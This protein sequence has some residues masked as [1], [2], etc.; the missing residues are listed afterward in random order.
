MIKFILITLL[1]SA[2]ILLP[3]QSS[4]GL[5]N[6]K[7]LKTNQSPVT[8]FRFPLTKE[9]VSDYLQVKE[10][11]LKKTMTK[12][13]FSDE[14]TPPSPDYSSFEASPDI[15]PREQLA[16]PIRSLPPVLHSSNSSD[17]GMVV[18]YSQSNSLTPGNNRGLNSNVEAAPSLPSSKKT[19]K[20]KS[21]SITR[22]FV[23]SPA[24]TLDQ[25]GSTAT[26][27]IDPTC[28]L[29]P[30]NET[31]VLF[32]EERLQFIGYEPIP[33]GYSVQSLL[34]LMPRI[35]QI[36]LFLNVAMSPTTSVLTSGV[37]SGADMVSTVFPKLDSSL[38]TLVQFSS[39]QE[40]T[41]YLT[42]RCFSAFVCVLGL[43]WLVVAPFRI[44]QTIQQWAAQNPDA[45]DAIIRSFQT[46]PD[47]IMQL[48]LSLEDEHK[49]SLLSPDSVLS[50]V[51]ATSKWNFLSTN[52]PN[53]NCY[54]YF[55]PVSA[56]VTEPHQQF[57]LLN[58]IQVI[59]SDQVPPGLQLVQGL[60][61]FLRLRGHH[62]VPFAIPFLEPEKPFNKTL[63]YLLMD[64]IHKMV[65]PDD[66]LPPEGVT[67]TSSPPHPIHPQGS[68]GQV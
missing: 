27:P 39:R 13:I 55:P 54:G 22:F 24:A 15:Q 45:T 20:R 19:R 46:I 62:Q 51:S 4:V 32:Q 65:S 2:T 44:C 31:P 52:P 57:P 3:R 16:H 11:D 29:T 25:S 12:E 53:V 23:S 67:R 50:P 7:F 5:Y 21:S 47:A 36:W 61:S 60:P 28:P 1:T 30:P 14:E 8:L 26:L 38:S 43:N 17:R 68:G 41:S 35:R 40:L 37:C 33:T 66:H 34:S 56:L 42:D 58:Q 9:L 59:R 63:V 6:F 18:R 49:I 48:S 64:T 10:M